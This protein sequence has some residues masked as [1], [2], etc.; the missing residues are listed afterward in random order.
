MTTIPTPRPDPAALIRAAMERLNGSAVKLERSGWVEL[1]VG[2]TTVRLRPPFLGEYR[3]FRRASTTSAEQLATEAVDEALTAADRDERALARTVAWWRDVVD[4][5]GTGDT[6]LPNDVD[7]W[8]IWLVENSDPIV[9]LYAHWRE[10]PGGPG[11]P[12]R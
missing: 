9:C 5:L 11:G 8:S 12:G 2:E 4:T 7:E 3:R 1:T 10:V 6:Q